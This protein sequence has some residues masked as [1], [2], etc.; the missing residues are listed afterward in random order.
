MA[1]IAA[2]ASKWFRAQYRQSKGKIADDATREAIGK[3]CPICGD[4]VIVCL[5]KG[6]ALRK[7]F[8]DEDEDED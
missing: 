6:E 1:R 3:K 7:R 8:E 2:D 4:D 5:K